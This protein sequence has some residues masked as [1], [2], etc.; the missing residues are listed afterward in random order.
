[1]TNSD[2]FYIKSWVASS[3]H[4]AQLKLVCP[5]PD[6]SFTDMFIPYR[7]LS[8]L[9]LLFSSKV[10]LASTQEINTQ[11]LEVRYDG[12]QCPTGTIFAGSQ[13]I[14][15]GAGITCSY[16]DG[17]DRIS[18]TATLKH[19]AYRDERHCCY[20]NGDGQSAFLVT[21]Y[22]SDRDRTGFLPTYYLD[23]SYC[24][25]IGDE[26]G[27]SFVKATVAGLDD[28]C[29]IGQGR[30]PIVDS[31]EFVK[32]CYRKSTEQWSVHFKDHT[33]QVRQVIGQNITQKIEFP[34]AVFSLPTFDFTIVI[35]EAR[36]YRHHIEVDVYIP[37]VGERTLN[38]EYTEDFKDVLC[39]D[40]K[41]GIGTLYTCLQTK[42][43]DGKIFAKV[44]FTGRGVLGRLDES[45]DLPSVDNELAASFLQLL[46]CDA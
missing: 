20:Y 23:G 5:L 8:I 39:F 44:H 38:V 43:P 35:G 11:I 7:C 41:F 13:N 34:Q 14:P 31:S 10:P 19:K 45:R 3:A 9:L 27:T 12:L 29:Q 24:C 15:A 4:S 17:A 46:T 30:M 32:C 21:W 28:E 42:T 37:L 18:G 33:P 25:N 36:L 16:T 22:P 1:M 2:Q 26:E 6:P 40:L